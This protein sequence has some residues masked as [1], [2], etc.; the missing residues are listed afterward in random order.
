MR[1]MKSNLLNLLL[2]LAL[3]FLV[4]QAEAHFEFNHKI[5]YWITVIQCILKSRKWSFRKYV[6]FILNFLNSFRQ[7]YIL[8]GNSMRLEG[9]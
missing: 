6:S 2:I 7:F 4:H 9:F 5:I 3:N 8:Y 1:P